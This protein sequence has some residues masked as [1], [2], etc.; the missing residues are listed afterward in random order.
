MTNADLL[1]PSHVA[2]MGLGLMGGSLA[3]ALRDKCEFITGID[4]DPA[5]LELALQM[6]IADQVSSEPAALL[7]KAD[8]L[9]LAA[10]VNSILTILGDLPELHPGSPVVMDIGSTKV[11][12]VEAM[13]S[14]PARFDPIGGHP[15]CG[16]ARPSLAYAEA[17]IFQGA[18]FAF[19]PLSRTSQKTRQLAG[20]LAGIVGSVPLWLDPETHDRWVGA[21]SHLPYLV[22]N[23]LA[24]TTPLDASPLVGPGFR[25]TARLSTSALAMMLDILDTNRENVLAGL[26]RFKGHLASLETHLL[27]RDRDSLRA[28]LEKGGEKFDILCGLKE[29]GESQ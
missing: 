5:V 1:A 10:P 12:I 4:P 20:Q 13:R 8:I 6:N 27:N 14:L 23:T 3:M 15:M 26:E 24:Y 19:T 2:I 11:Q 22:A 7:P 17:S 18:V 9:I 16:K 21:T 29:T 28:L 25:S